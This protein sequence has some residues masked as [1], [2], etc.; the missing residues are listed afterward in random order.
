MI[1]NGMARLFV[2]KVELNCEK[3]FILG[4]FSSLEH[5]DCGARGD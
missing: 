2:G 4:N 5:G 3:G 1:N